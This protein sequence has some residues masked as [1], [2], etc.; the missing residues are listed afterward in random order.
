ME[1]SDLVNREAIPALEKMLA[2]TQARQRMLTEN[3]ANVDTP[4]YRTKHLDVGAFQRA[5]RS[6]LESNRQTGGA[7]FELKGTD[8]F[9]LDSAGRLEVRPS[10]EPAENVLFHDGTN[11]RIERQMAMMAENAMMHQAAT[12]LLRTKFEGLLKAIRGRV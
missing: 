4:G 11:V 7:S 2:F 9:R 6:A 12:E 1:F 8:E 5:L 10:E 3:I